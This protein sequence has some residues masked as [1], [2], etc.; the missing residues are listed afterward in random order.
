MSFKR[1]LNCHFHIF[2]LIIS[3]LNEFSFA[4]LLI[5][6]YVSKIGYYL[7]LEYSRMGETVAKPQFF[8]VLCGFMNIV[9]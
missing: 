7:K 4:D 8:S 6:F 1:Q 3:I 9:L 2:A 5:D